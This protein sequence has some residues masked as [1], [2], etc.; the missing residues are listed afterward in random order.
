MV[1]IWLENLFEALNLFSNSNADDAH[2]CN[3]ELICLIHSELHH[4]DRSLSS[5]YGSSHVEDDMSGKILEEELNRLYT[6]AYN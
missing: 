1:N 2:Q 3:D 5:T 6:L 4:E